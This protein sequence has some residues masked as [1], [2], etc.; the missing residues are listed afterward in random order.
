MSILIQLPITAGLHPIT[1]IKHIQH[2][3]FIDVEI[4]TQI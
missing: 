4:K 2:A 3:Y 1:T